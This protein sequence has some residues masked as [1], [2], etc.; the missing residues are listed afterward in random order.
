MSKFIILVETGADVPADMAEQY[1]IVKV[2]MHVSFGSET[3]DDGAFPTTDLF[4]YYK[5]TGKLPQTS[6]CTPH[7]FEVVFDE[8]HEKYP[9]SHLLHLGYSA[10]TTCSLQSAILAAK[11]R[12]YV[13]SIDT[14][15]VS[16]GQALVTLCTARY[17]EQHPDCS[18]EE[19]TAEVIRLREK[20]RMGFLPGD[21]V[22]LK[23]GG[24]VSNA[25]YLGAKLLNLSPLIEIRDGRLDATKK[26]RGDMRKIAMKLLDEFTEEQSLS[27]ELMAFVYSPGLPED[28]KQRLEARAKELGFQE[29]RWI[30]TGC[31]VSTHSGPAAFGVS[32]FSERG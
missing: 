1:G 18:V 17:L 7:D 20:C 21:L 4:S 8:L 9:D 6:G 3:K 19:V 22:Y 28:L 25:A 24:R 29:I 26:Y 16:A 11:G 15:H 27:R 30:E 2:P 23:A 12:D 32:G 14:K 5:S 13:T 31:V 10:A